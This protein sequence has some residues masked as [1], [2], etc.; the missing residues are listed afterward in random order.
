M[1]S[2][3]LKTWLTD[4]DWY[5]EAM[6][7]GNLLHTMEDPSEDDRE[8]AFRICDSCPVRVECIEAALRE[9]WVS[10]FCAGV[11]IPDPK[12]KA[13]VRKVWKLLEH[14]LPGEREAQRYV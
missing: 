7:G 13:E 3:N 9:Q 12:H 5:F 10:V 11:Y 6:C 2:P 8:E 14:M 1:W 4:Q